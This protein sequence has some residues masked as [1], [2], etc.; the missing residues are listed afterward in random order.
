MDETGLY[1]LIHCV[2]Q[3]DYSW[4]VFFVVH[5]PLAD[6]ELGRVEVL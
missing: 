6:G 3:L 1:V 5:K 2:G 4:Q